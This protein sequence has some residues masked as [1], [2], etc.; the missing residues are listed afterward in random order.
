MA[1]G[2]RA[3]SNR[4]VRED[5]IAASSTTIPIVPASKSSQSTAED[6]R[7][8]P[9]VSVHNAENGGGMQKVAQLSKNPQRNKRLIRKLAR[10]GYMSRDGIWTRS[11]KRKYRKSKRNKL[12]LA[13]LVVL[14]L[15]AGSVFTAFKLHLF[16]KFGSGKNAQNSSTSN[17]LSGVEEP[18]SDAPPAVTIE[19]DPELATKFEKVV[20]EHF[21]VQ[22]FRAVQDKNPLFQKIIRI[23]K[24]T[25]NR[26]VVRLTVLYNETTKDQ[27]R[28]LANQLIK[29]TQ[30]KL[31]NLEAVTVASKDNA[32]LE[33]VLRKKDE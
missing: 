23:T 33:T 16:D 25:G 18:T 29:L 15:A 7:L 20:K 1:K 32:Y 5:R 22:N 17:D 2:K 14:V 19:E 24:I 13:L 26:V 28:D 27:V 12:L 31:P 3:K 21:N 6:L 30:D 4:E 8:V 10:K 11:G 9:V